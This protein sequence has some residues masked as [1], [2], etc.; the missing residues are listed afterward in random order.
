MS[1]E[2]TSAWHADVQLLGRYVAGTLPDAAAWSVES[3]LTAC[4]ACRSRLQTER[5]LVDGA[6]L[7]E[8]WEHVADRVRR[9]ERSGLERVLVRSGLAEH[10]ARLLVATPS[11][12]ASWLLGIVL[13]LSA[14]VAVAWSTP[15]GSATS[16]FVFLL[17]APLVPLA[18]VAVAFGPGVDPTYELG[19][20]AP[21]SS[22]RLLLLRAVAVVAT[23]IVLAAL[24]SLA[25]PSVG[26]ASVAW[27]V[28]SLSLTTAA[29]AA[30]IRWRLRTA[31]GAV[32]LC[33]VVV[34]GGVERYGETSLAA[35]GS[36]GQGM[37]TIV[38]VTSATVLAAG[39]GRIDPAARP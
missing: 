1:G 22:A 35:F 38:L 32:A 25:L 9:R 8:I 29:L 4:A 13:V 34:A 26:W 3:H 39:H 7:E 10:D 17:L 15:L 20:V 37:A 16:L 33:W 21:L 27:L 31:A 24:A 14:S 19:I 6:R 30:S 2:P 11:L 36:L 18:G 28:P 5:Q 23:S 12:T